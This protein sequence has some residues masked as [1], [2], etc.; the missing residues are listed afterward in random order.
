MEAMLIYY[1]GKGEKGKFKIFFQ[2]GEVM[3]HISCGILLFMRG[4]PYRDRTCD[5]GLKSPSVSMHYIA[6]NLPDRGVIP[7]RTQILNRV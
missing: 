5:L 7:V 3:S 4:A 1:Y 2:L 6:D